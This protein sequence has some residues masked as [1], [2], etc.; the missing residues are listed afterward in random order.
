MQDI[1]AVLSKVYEQIR[2]ES[3]KDNESRNDIRVCKRPDLN[4]N[5]QELCEGMQALTLGISEQ[6]QQAL[7]AAQQTTIPDRLTGMIDEMKDTYDSFV[8][9]SWIGVRDNGWTTCLSKLAKQIQILRPYENAVPH[10]EKEEDDRL[11]S[12]CEELPNQQAGIVRLLWNRKHKTNWDTIGQKKEL[13]QK[14]RNARMMKR[15]IGL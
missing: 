2:N 7:Q 5:P 4:E 10:E 15:F 8:N 9:L 12:L 3:R 11:E 14:K 6:Y 13:W 1:S